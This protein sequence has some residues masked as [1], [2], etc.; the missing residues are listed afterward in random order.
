VNEMRRTLK[1]PG[2][3]SIR[4]ELW[5]AL[6]NK[7]PTPK[8]MFPAIK[9]VFQKRLGKLPRELTKYLNG[10]DLIGLDINKLSEYLNN[11]YHEY[12]AQRE[13]RLAYHSIF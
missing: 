10:D 2:A 8:Q 13:V 7:N 12:T 6:P 9:S 1:D 3:E 4:K 11:L 5:R